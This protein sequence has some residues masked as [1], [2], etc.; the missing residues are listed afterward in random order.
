[1]RPSST[2]SVGPTGQSHCVGQPEAEERRHATDERGED[3]KPFHVAR[4][5]CAVSAGISR[6]PNEI[7]GPTLNTAMETV[8][9]MSR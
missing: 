4:E 2:T 5:Q 1:M 7:S 6:K 9:P 8:K 3:D